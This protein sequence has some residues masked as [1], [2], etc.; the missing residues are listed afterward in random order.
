MFVREVA[1]FLGNKM[2]RNPLNHRAV[3]WNPMCA[4][5][6]TVLFGAT[7]LVS[8]PVSAEDIRAGNYLAA[9]HAGAVGDHANAAAYYDAVIA[10]D[11]NNENLLYTAAMFFLADGQVERAIELSERLAGQD[12]KN[13]TA[14]LLAAI[15]AAKRG[16][17]SRATALSID[18]PESGLN[19]LLAPM[20]QAWTLVGEGRVDAGMEALGKLGSNF[21]YAPFEL[22]MSALIHRFTGDSESTDAAFQAALEFGAG[23]RQVEAYGNFLEQQD[24][25]D[26][27]IALYQSFLEAQPSEVIAAAL[28]RAE[29]GTRAAPMI[30]SVTDGLAEVFHAVSSSLS[31]E[32]NAANPTRNFARMAVYLRP[33]FDAALMVLANTMEREDAYEAA[34]RVLEQV[35]ADSVYSWEAR[36]QTALNLSN[37]EKMDE[38]VTLLRA[39]AAERPASTEALTTLGNVLRRNDQFA[40]AAEAY[41]RAIDRIETVQPGNWTLLYAR[42]TTYERSDQ[43]EKAEADFLRALELQPEQPYVLNYLGYSWIELGRNVEEATQMIVRA[44]EQQPTAGFIVDSLGWGH[45]KLENYEEAARHLER[46]VQLTPG[47]PTINDHLGDAYWR[48]GRKRE[49]VFQWQHALDL[50]AEEDVIPL[51]QDKIANGLGD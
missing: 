40:E 9:R 43:W 39:M 19:R 33:G 5:L 3:G 30:A 10:V 16:D 25:M 35:P 28:A 8:G 27:A 41:S 7:I 49:A 32:N 44:V 17:F 4:A 37:L 36:M 15:G 13:G 34:V 51:I 46:A 18:V 38:A 1:P 22:Y 50:G 21:Q 47:D 45:Y 12:D 11:P 29:G 6:A 24:R 23:T 26:D 14:V 48:V 31:Q 20:V 2:D 42:G